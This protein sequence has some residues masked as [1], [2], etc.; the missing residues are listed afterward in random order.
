MKKWSIPGKITGGECSLVVE[1]E[2]REEAI[3]LLRSSDW[4]AEDGSW[5]CDPDVD[6]N[7]DEAIEE[8]LQEY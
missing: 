5:E 7:D 3:R 8:A 1:A 6:L 2:T 4:E